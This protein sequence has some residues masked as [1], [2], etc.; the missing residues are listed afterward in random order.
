MPAKGQCK[1]SLKQIQDGIKDYFATCDATVRTVV[2]GK[3]TAVVARPYTMVG[4]ADHLGIHKDT[5]YQWLN[6]N[7]P[8]DGTSKGNAIQQQ[9]TDSITRAK[10]RIETSL[11]ERSLTGELDS[12]TAA[13]IL[14]GMGY[15]SR[16]EVQHSGNMAVQ[17]QG[18]T[19]EEA[20]EWAK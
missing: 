10:G 18:T 3:R 14:G 7:Y 11:L 17:W 5:L 1:L 20:A 4:L 19:P 9:V 15:T 12:R 16:Q 8:T 6:G 13:L 2:I